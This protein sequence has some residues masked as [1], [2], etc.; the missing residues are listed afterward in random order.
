MPHTCWSGGA[1]ELDISRYFTN[2]IRITFLY[3]GLVTLKW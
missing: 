3:Y 1:M 2:I